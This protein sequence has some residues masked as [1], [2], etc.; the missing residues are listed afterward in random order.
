MAHDFKVG[1]TVRVND[2]G[3]WRHGHVGT[4]VKVNRVTIRVSMTEAPHGT[5]MGGKVYF[6]HVKEEVT[7]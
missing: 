1:D 7:C 5:V 3:W 4:V 2:P 6:E